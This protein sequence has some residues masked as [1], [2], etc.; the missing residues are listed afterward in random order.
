MKRLAICTAIFCLGAAAPA[1]AAW[2]E[3]GTVRVSFAR[4]HDT[5]SFDMGGPVERLQ[6]R[7]D[8]SDITC[9]DVKATFGNGRSRSIFQGALRDGNPAAID[10]PGDARAISRLTF[11]CGAQ[12]RRGGNIVVVADVGA[13]R[14]EWRRNPRFASNWSRAFNWGSDM[15]ND[16]KYL[17]NVKFRGRN[18]SDSSYAGLGGKNIDAVALKPLDA[19]AR[20]SRVTARFGNGHDQALSVNNGDYLRR[21]Q[22]YKLD[23]PGRA[24]D[25]VSLNL[26]CRATDA[27]AVTIQIYTSR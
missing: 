21:G 11:D 9:R 12:N 14:A 10:L 4:D 22:Y 18:D 13:N 6:L 24:R 23:L 26:R 3:V 20:C 8:G 17:D 15:V 7:A 25:L 2:N 19:D 1:L 5:K 16:W 27:R